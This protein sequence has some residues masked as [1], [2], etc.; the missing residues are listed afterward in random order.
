MEIDVG[1]A[2]STIYRGVR[3]KSTLAAIAYYT[4]MRVEDLIEGTEMIDVWYG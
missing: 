1:V 2:K 4:G 3:Y